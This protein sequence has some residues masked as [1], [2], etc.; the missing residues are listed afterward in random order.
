MEVVCIWIP[1]YSTAHLE[2]RLK[3]CLC[4]VVEESIK[5]RAGGSAENN[6]SRP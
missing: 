6:K 3:V 5:L 1:V 2:F 4:D